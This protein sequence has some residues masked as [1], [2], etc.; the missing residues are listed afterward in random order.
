M[1]KFL[2]IFFLLINSAFAEDTL[3]KVRIDL[4]DGGHDS[5]NFSAAISP[6]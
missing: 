3:Q 2:L 1:K 5:A 4:F 6:S